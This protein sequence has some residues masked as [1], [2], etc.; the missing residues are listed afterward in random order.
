M[1]MSPL[2]HSCWYFN[3]KRLCF[4]VLSCFCHLIESLLVNKKERVKIGE[5]A[6]EGNKTTFVGDRL[7]SPQEMVFFGFFFLGLITCLAD[8]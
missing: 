2:A 1:L 6:G 3:V 8:R 7:D 5:G 4:G